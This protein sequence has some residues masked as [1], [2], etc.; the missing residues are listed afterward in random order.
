MSYLYRTDEQQA[1]LDHL[2]HGPYVFADKPYLSTMRYSLSGFEPRD[3]AAK[4]LVD[5]QGINDNMYWFQKGKDW[6]V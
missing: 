5:E 4:Q 2:P 6:E 3:I 1:A